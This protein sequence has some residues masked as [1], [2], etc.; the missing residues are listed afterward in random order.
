MEPGHCYR[1]ARAGTTGGRGRS[2]S[3]AKGGEEHWP[4]SWGLTEALYRE[5]PDRQPCDFQVVY[6]SP[7][8]LRTAEGKLADRQLS[9]C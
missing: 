6:L 8:H 7:T 4:L 9:D 5:F 1:I 2:P 3:Y